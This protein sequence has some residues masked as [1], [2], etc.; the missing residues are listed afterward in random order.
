[1]I[2]EETSSLHSSELAKLGSDPEDPGDEIWRLSLLI[3]MMKEQLDK[4][5]E[6]CRGELSLENICFL[7]GIQDW[8]DNMLYE[9]CEMY[10]RKGRKKSPERR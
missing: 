3:R 7:E 8:C 5:T 4:F 2:I 10:S 9:S 6:E 1:M